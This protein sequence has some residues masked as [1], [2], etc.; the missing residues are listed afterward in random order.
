MSEKKT[1]FS[2]K[3]K[4]ERK[5]KQTV[6]TGEAFTSRVWENRPFLDLFDYQ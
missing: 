1:V 3:K 4:K 5:K 2:P 6:M